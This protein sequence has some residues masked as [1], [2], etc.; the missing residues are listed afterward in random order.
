MLVSSNRHLRSE[1][2]DEARPA[3]TDL[4]TVSRVLLLL[5][6]QCTIVICAKRFRP[7]HLQPYQPRNMENFSSASVLDTLLDLASCKT[8]DAVATS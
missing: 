5:T 7:R 2:L 8:L 1:A 4:R 3:A 6:S